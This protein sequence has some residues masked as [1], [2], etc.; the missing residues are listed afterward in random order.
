M[1]ITEEEQTALS[2]MPV[3]LNM[4]T[5]LFV[6]PPAHG[7]LKMARHAYGYLNPVASA[8]PL[9]ATSEDAGGGQC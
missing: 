1:D 3:L 9:R 2:G 8:R 5:G 4:T 7:V 6:I